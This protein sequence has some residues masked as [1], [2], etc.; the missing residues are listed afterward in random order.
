MDG[1][2]SGLEKNKTNKAKLH[3]KEEEGMQH[4]VDYISS[5]G[6]VIVDSKALQ[7]LGKNQNKGRTGEDGTESVITIYKNTV[8]KVNASQ[9]M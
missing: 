6:L 9:I 5:K 1:F 7:D 2:S 4:F 3:N 8:N